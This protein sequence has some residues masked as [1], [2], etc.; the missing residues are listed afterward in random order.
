MSVDMT[1]N[2]PAKKTTPLT[3]ADDHLVLLKKMGNEK[4][5]AAKVLGP[6]IEHAEELAAEVVRLNHCID[7][8]QERYLEAQKLGLAKIVD[9]L[10]LEDENVEWVVNC[11][12]ELG[13]KIGNQLFF[14]Y[15]GRSL[16]YDKDSERDN[17]M[18]WRLVRKREFG[19]T[20]QVPD[21]TEHSDRGEYDRDGR[22][23]YGEGWQELP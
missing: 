11:G 7:G 10:V 4:S 22:Y 15:K 17:P 19:E 23:R 16:S 3:V 13:V 8:V 20:V 5:M 2:P 1:G 21:R 9:G 6:L 18:L 12:G 14:I